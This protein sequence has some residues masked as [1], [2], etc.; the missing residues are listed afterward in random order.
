MFMRANKHVFVLRG[1]YRAEATFYFVPRL[2]S[3]SR[4]Q[5]VTVVSLFAYLGVACWEYGSL[6]RVEFYTEFDRNSITGRICAANSCYTEIRLNKRWNVCYVLRERLTPIYNCLC[7]MFVFFGS[8]Y[9][10]KKDRKIENIG[11]Y[12][13]TWRLRK[14][15]RSALRSE[16][17][18]KI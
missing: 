5:F 15:D 18:L 3:M 17:S 8:K 11:V 14:L 1:S 4:V 6:F 2:R 13:A 16:T 12:V 10:W 7:R 9:F